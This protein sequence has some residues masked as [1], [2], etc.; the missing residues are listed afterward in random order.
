MV[1]EI[2]RELREA[3]VESADQEAVWLLQHVLGLSALRQTID[4]HRVLSAQEAVSV[5]RSVAR[6][7]GREPLQYILGMQ[8]F[9]GL[10]FEV[11]SSVLIPRPETELIPQAVVRRLPGDRAPVVVDVGTGSGC[12]AVALARTVPHGRVLATDLSSKALE[13]AKRNAERHGV[14]SAITWLQ[15]D[16]LTPLAGMDLERRISVIVSNPPYI[17]EGDWPTLQPEV[18]LHE[19]R[20]A[21]VAGPCGTELHERLVEQAVPFL[22]PGGFLIMEL[23]QGQSRVLV[24]LVKSHHAYRAIETISDDAGIERVLIAERTDH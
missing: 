10:E 19:P 16:L 17:T 8:E 22:R 7:V 14:A 4:R 5:R 6:R 9:C 21:L 18:R 2:R 24:D 3:G 23:G 1:S 20:T 15:G 12:L 13:V 11:N